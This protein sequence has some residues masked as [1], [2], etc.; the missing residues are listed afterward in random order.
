[1]CF[2]S[3]QSAP[4]SPQIVQAPAPSPTPVITPSEV[5]AQQAG[6]SRRKKL[7]QLRYGLASTIKTG[8]SGIMGAGAELK[9][10]ST[11][12]TKLGA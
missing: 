4:A 10:P 8:S 9:A 5:S 6:E 2:G 11:G 1:M 3:R 12:K 7:D